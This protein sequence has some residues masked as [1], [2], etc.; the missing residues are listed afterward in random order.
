[1]KIRI[2]TSVALCWDHVHDWVNVDVVSPV[3]R[4]DVALTLWGVGSVGYYVWYY[5]WLAGLYAAVLY[6]VMLLT[7][8]FMRDYL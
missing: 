8:F 7:G 6:G 1:M 5:G 3:R 4:I 2:P